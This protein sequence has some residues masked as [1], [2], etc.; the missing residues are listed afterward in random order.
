M[1]LFARTY[2]K[3]C[4]ALVLVDSPHEDM[5]RRCTAAGF[6]E[7]VCWPTPS[8]S[9]WAIL[10]TGVRAE[11]RG[12]AETEQQLRDA[13]P[14]VDV[15]LVVL[16]GLADKRDVSG[17]DISGLWLETQRLLAAQSANSGHVVLDHVGHN[18]PREQPAAVVEGIR[19][20]VAVARRGL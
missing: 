8:R 14:L 16:T 20:A 5:S 19:E 2:P 7:R 12:L 17:K 9:E 1:Q 11:I 10:P 3:E 6:G 18:I 15:P 4:A 13:P